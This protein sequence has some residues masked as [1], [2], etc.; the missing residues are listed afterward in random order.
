MIVSRAFQNSEDANGRR[1]QKAWQMEPGSMCHVHLKH[2]MDQNGLGKKG[3][4]RSEEGP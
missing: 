3:S 1:V 2:D 4:Q